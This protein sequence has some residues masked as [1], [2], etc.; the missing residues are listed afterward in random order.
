LVADLIPTLNNVT[1]DRSICFAYN[2]RFVD[3]LQ[4]LDYLR[5]VLLEVI[6]INNGYY[7]LPTLV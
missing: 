3:R 5:E 4:Q 7:G 1:N 2:L 6:V